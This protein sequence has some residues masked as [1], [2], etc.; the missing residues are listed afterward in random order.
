MYFRDI[1]ILAADRW[2]L[3]LGRGRE[4]VR[5]RDRLHLD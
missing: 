3:R 2:D 4:L 5:R 1:D